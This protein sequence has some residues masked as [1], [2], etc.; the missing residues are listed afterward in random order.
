M[1]YASTQHT[2]WYRYVLIVPVFASLFFTFSC[3]EE[4]EVAQLD[5]LAQQYQEAETQEERSTLSDADE[6]FMVV[7]DQP[8][9]EEGM[10]AFYTYVG[11]NLKYPTEARQKGIEGKVFVQFVVDKD[12]S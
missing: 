10:K 7:E 9:P 5:D 12:G 3:Q 2:P 6:V 11:E 1:M 8:T 4:S